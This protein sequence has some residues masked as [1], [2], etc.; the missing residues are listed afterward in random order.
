MTTNYVKIGITGSR[1]ITNTRWICNILHKHMLE[2]PDSVICL[3]VGD[4]DGVDAI[5]YNYAQQSLQFAIQ[6][7]PA[8]KYIPLLYKH[9]GRWGN[10]LYHARNMQVVDNCDELIALWDGKSAGT[11][12]TK[13][14]ADKIGRDY[15]VY[16][17]N[18]RTKGM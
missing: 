5:A 17:Y 8:H 13:D 3:I 14:Y 15:T 2:Y 9:L 18:E 4:A 1:S 7:K 10:K 6:L 12:Q 16:I 11:R